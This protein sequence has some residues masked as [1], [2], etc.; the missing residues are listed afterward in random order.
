MRG[1]VDHERVAANSVNTAS[2]V[3][4]LLSVWSDAVRPGDDTAIGL[5]D[6]STV[7]HVAGRSGLAGRYEGSDTILGLLSLFDDLAGGVLGCRTPRIMRFEHHAMVFGRV[8]AVSNRVDFSAE[9][10]CLLEFKDRTITEMWMFSPDAGALDQLS[11]R[12]RP[13]AE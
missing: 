5:F 2:D 8:Q 6:D 13:R 1:S 11:A 4:S 9:T 7:L 3:R 12:R 10:V